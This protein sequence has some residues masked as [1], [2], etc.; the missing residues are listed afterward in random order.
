MIFRLSYSGDTFHWGLGPF[1]L[2]E[3]AEND[4]I[5]GILASTGYFFIIIILIIGI[6]LGDESKFAV[7]GF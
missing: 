7:K 6:A 3:R 2:T 1:S 5:L 4:L